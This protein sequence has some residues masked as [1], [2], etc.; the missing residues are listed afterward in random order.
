MTVTLIWFLITSALTLF[1]FARDKSRAA[2][3]TGRRVPERTLLWLALLG[4]TPGV[5]AGRWLFRHKTRKQPF[6]LRLH[7]IALGQ[8][9]L[10]AVAVGRGWIG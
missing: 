7:L 4:G 10:L 9:L 8:A 5:Y 6:V 1:L 2:R 3:R